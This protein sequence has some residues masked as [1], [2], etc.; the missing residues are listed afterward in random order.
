MA[1][2]MAKLVKRIDRLD[3]KLDGAYITLPINTQGAT[4]V[5]AIAEQHV[6]KL[7]RRA[8]GRKIQIKT[9]FK[10]ADGGYT[11]VNCTEFAR[12]MNVLL[13]IADKLPT[14]KFIALFRR[15]GTKGLRMIRI[16]TK[17]EFFAFHLVDHMIAALI[18]GLSKSS[19]SYKELFK[20]IPFGIHSKN[21]HRMGRLLNMPSYL[22]INITTAAGAY[23]VFEAMG[24]KY[25]FNTKPFKPTTKP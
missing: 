12:K 2:P 1:G 25:R 7:R 11:T 21:V 8:H 4:G 5:C 10:N 13:G 23:R 20:V 6:A 9:S 15:F 22:K 24:R 17:E 3:G 14:F 19:D 18:S 16:P